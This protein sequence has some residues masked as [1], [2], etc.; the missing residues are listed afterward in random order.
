[1]RRKIMNNYIKWKDI[2]TASGTAEHIPDAIKQLNSPIAIDRDNAY[3][4]IDNY[5]VVQSDLYEAAYYVIEPL[6]EL[7]EKPYSVDRI[8]PLRLLSE[9]ATGGGDSDI[10]ELK[11]I[12]SGKGIFKSIHEAC[13]IKISSL[14]YRIAQIVTKTEEEKE[15]KDFLMRNI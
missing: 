4:Q 3:W 1:M 6:V 12:H 8:K 13:K 5:A 7:L 2:K 14:K 9:I 10:I 15:E 11:D